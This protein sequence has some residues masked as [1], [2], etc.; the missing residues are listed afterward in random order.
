QVVLD[1]AHSV[2]SSW[3]DIDNDGDLDLLVANDGGHDNFLYLNDG[4]E[5]NW[6]NIR[7]VGITSNASAIGC[8]VRAKAMINSVPRWQTRDI[9]GQ[10]GFS[11]QHSLNVEFGLADAAQ[12]DSLI[13]H[14]SSG[15]RQVLTNI[16]ANQFITIEEPTTI[17]TMETVSGRP[18]QLVEVPLNGAFPE[19]YEFYAAELKLSGFYGKLTLEDILLDSAIV[20][21]SGWLCEYNMKDSVLSIWMAG[22]EPVHGAGELLRLQFTV[23]GIDDNFVP[24][25]INYALFD[26]GEIPVKKVSGGMNILSG[27]AEQKESKN[28]KQPLVAADV[29]SLGQN[30]PNPFNPNTTIEYSLAESGFVQLHIYNEVGHIVRTLINGFQSKGRYSIM[31]NGTDNAG[32]NVASGTYFY[33]MKSGSKVIDAKRMTLVK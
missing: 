32:K 3:G 1:E 10:T 4:N 11:S 18:N 19:N 16:A 23:H 22:M 26:T 17:L 13:I 28:E 20:G 15:V 9:S 5:N 25:T 31:W 2:G 8:I 6:I 7:C 30:Y 33:L 24:V 12:I 29:Y 27:F 21:S 14:W